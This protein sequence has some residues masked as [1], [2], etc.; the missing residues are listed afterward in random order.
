MGG[1]ANQQIASYLGN[2]PSRGNS[3]K[4][5]I[6]IFMEGHEVALF[7]GWKT[8]GLFQSG[9]T[10]YPINGSM[11]QPGDIKVLD[12]NGDGVVDLADSMALR[13]MKLLME[14]ITDLDG[15]KVLTEIFLLMLGMTG[16]HLIIPLLHIQDLVIQLTCLVLLW[17]ELLR[18]EVI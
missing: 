9:D 6:N 13:E 3:I 4:F 2:V 18:M 10:M 16:G 8:D 7:Y 5:P 17:T 15:L 14:T 1:Y 12:L 11:S